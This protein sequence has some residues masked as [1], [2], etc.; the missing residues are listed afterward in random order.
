VAADLHRAFAVAG[1]TRPSPLRFAEYLDRRGKEPD[2]T[3]RRHL[4]EIGGAIEV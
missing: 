2:Y 3:L 1:T 4:R